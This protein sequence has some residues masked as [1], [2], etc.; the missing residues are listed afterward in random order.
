MAEYTPAQRTHPRLNEPG[1]QSL[2]AQLHGHDDASAS[3]IVRPMVE[4]RDLV[5]LEVQVS[6]QLHLPVRITQKLVQHIPEH[7]LKQC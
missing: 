6:Q 5:G 4:L 1:G 7:I 3:G 2:L